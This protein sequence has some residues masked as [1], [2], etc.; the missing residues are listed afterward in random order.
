MKEYNKIN[1]NNH[2]SLFSS[3]KSKSKEFFIYNIFLLKTKISNQNMNVKI[4]L[5][6]IILLH[7]E[8]GSLQGKNSE[9]EEQKNNNN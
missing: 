4:M 1:N 5:I 3:L 2:F 9:E 6:I 7:R 8:I